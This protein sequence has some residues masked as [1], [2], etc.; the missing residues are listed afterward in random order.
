MQTATPTGRR[1][2]ARRTAPVKISVDAATKLFATRA[3]TRPRPRTSPRRPTSRSERSSV[4]SRRRRQCCT[5]TWTICSFASVRSST[6]ARAPKPSCRRCSESILALCRRLRRPTQAP[7][8]LQARLASSYPSVSAY[9]RRRAARLGDE[10]WPNRSGGAWTSVVTSDLRPEII[11]A[12]AMAALRHSIRRWAKSG[13][14][15]ELPTLVAP[16]PSTRYTEVAEAVRPRC[17]MRRCDERRL[18]SPAVR[19]I[20]SSTSC[21]LDHGVAIRSA[22][23]PERFLNAAMPLPSTMLTKAQEWTLEQMKANQ[24]Q[25]DRPQQE[26]RFPRR[27]AARMKVPFRRS[28]ARPEGHG[29]QA[30]LRLPHEVDR[31]EP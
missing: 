6:H 3:S 31:G 1:L 12:A 13:G 10:S 7:D 29:E 9:S 30:M 23:T 17:E 11:A 14:R 4:T 25:S 18:R 15:G 16:R 26:G 22:H 28:P 24:E 20:V 19:P 21:L 2:T 5:A 8:L 27:E